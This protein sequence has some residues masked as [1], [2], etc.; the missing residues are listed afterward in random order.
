MRCQGHHV[1]RP[2]SR[3]GP[4]PAERARRSISPSRLP[5]A[6]RRVHSSRPPLPT[7]H[8][9]RCARRPPRKRVAPSACSL[10]VVSSTFSTP[11]SVHSSLGKGESPVSFHR[12][13]G[14][15]HR[16]WRSARPALLAP[17]PSLL[18]LVLGPVLATNARRVT[19]SSPGAVR[20]SR[21][22][23]GRALPWL[24]PLPLLATIASIDGFTR[25]ARV[26]RTQ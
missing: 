3:R 21:S 9:R 25:C 14:C 6:Q 22:S 20:R 23:R 2:C 15:S 8:R 13:R 17:L 1:A 26:R 5:R 16:R 12:L 24:S 4:A 11:P 10:A 7:E 19:H 18:C